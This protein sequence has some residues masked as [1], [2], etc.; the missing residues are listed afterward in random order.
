MR[1]PVLS[2]GVVLSALMLADFL[3]TYYALSG[4]YSEGN[5]FLSEII[6]NIYHFAAVKLFGTVIIIMMYLKIYKDNKKVAKYGMFTILGL[7]SIVVI[8][9]ILVILRGM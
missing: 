8:N 4:G 1:A 9:N 5:I 7:M 2:F 3:T 6:Q